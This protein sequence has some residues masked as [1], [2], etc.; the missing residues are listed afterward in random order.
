MNTAGQIKRNPKKI[1]KIQTKANIDALSKN[2]FEIQSSK[3]QEAK[4]N[5]EYMNN[6]YTNF[7]EVLDKVY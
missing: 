6:F 3:V 1:R 7:K 2:P 5:A 4:R